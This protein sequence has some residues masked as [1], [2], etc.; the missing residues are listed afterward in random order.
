MSESKALEGLFARLAER[1]LTVDDYFTTRQEQVTGELTPAKF[2]L[3]SG[4]SQVREL[5][6][7]AEVVTGVRELGS[8][9]VEVKRYKGLGEM[10]PDELWETTMNP[11]K[12]TLLKVVLTDEPEDAEQLE[13]DAREA[14][15]IF[16]ILMGDDV[17][18]RRQF[19]E[20]NAIHVK[21]LDI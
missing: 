8:R 20:T 21:N 11:E 10:N 15:R 3:V 4:E 6:N 14:D 13:I 16:S 7:A 12:R 1:G 9:G 2:V 18:T 17:E 5:N 19:I